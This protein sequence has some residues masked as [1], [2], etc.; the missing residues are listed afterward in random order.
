MHGR[1]YGFGFV[2]LTLL[3]GCAESPLSPPHDDP[4][5]ALG[6]AFTAAATGTIRGRITWIGAIPTSE[7]SLVRAIAFNSHLHLNPARFSTPHVPKVHSQS[8]GVE[9]AVVFL[10]GIDPRRSKAWDHPPARV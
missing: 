2:C 5:A 10:R 9:N 4:P 6:E 3:G 7:E 8:R 1:L